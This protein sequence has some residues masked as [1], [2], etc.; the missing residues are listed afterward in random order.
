[1]F[2]RAFARFKAAELLV[3]CFKFHRPIGRFKN[4]TGTCNLIPET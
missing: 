3:S 2:H 1:M 4:Q